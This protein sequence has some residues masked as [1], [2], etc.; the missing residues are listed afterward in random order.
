MLKHLIALGLCFSLH[1]I[2][3]IAQLPEIETVRQQEQKSDSVAP[4][5]GSRPFLEAQVQYN[6]TDSLAFDFDNQKMYLYGKAEIKY[7]DIELTA[8]AIELDLDS[9]LAIAYG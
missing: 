6:A 3:S 2:I 1:S 4:I 8:H 9:T 7:L 5:K